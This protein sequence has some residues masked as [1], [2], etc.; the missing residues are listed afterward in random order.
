MYNVY[1]QQ[2]VQ[3][4]PPPRPV[5]NLSRVRVICVYSELNEIIIAEGGGGE[6]RRRRSWKYGGLL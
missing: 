5:S 2:T 4:S 1:V 6:R 3:P